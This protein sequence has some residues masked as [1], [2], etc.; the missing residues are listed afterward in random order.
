MMKDYIK[1]AESYLNYQWPGIPATKSLLIERTGNRSEYENISFKKRR[2][3]AI[4]YS[5]FSLMEQHYL[6]HYSVSQYAEQVGVCP[7]HLTEVCKTITGKSVKQVLKERLLLE[8]KRYL[9]YSKL[10][11]KEISDRLNFN[12][13]G[14]FS[15]FFKQAAYKS[16]S[17]FRRFDSE[18]YK[19]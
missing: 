18:L 11:I 12:D 17:D 16:P 5:F 2:D 19:N 1:E 6:E 15:R 7:K 13:Y 8:A 10:S 9:R 14:Y 3:M 4:Y